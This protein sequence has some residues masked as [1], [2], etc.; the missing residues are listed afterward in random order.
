LEYGANARNLKTTDVVD[1]ESEEQWIQRMDQLADDN[2]LVIDDFLAESEMNAL[3]DFFK[4]KQ[5][6]DVLNKA[7]IG[8]LNQYTIDKSIRGDY[9]KWLDESEDPRVDLYFDRVKSLIKILN[10]YCYLSLS[11]VEI[12]L[13][14]YPKGTFYKRHFDQFEKRNN[15]MISV[16]L[17]LNREWQQGDGGELVAYLPEGE[18]KVIAPIAN[19]LV[20]MR[21]NIVEHEV[22][23]TQADRRSVTGWLLYQ[24]LG[25][26]FLAT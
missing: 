20:L 23:M 16:I 11:G 3:C 2:Y 21:S 5:D 13:A 6:E 26:S 12:H 25:L 24:P 19:R 17:Y 14:H 7:G 15:R 8:T 10:R 4:E 22:L 1:F 18:E 9:I